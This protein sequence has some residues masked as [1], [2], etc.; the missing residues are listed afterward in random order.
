MKMLIALT[1]K[2]WLAAF[3]ILSMPA[4]G[5]MTAMAEEPAVKKP[6]GPAK[7][8]QSADAA[9]DRLL[10]TYKNAKTYRDEGLIVINLQTPGGKEPGDFD[11]KLE[12]Q[13]PNLLRMEFQPP[14]PPVGEISQRLVISDGKQVA[15]RSDG[16]ANQVLVANTPAQDVA[17][18]L[19]ASETVGPLLTDGL[20]GG[21]LMLKLLTSADL[22]APLDRTK[23][24]LLEQGKHEDQTFDRVQF[25]TKE[26]DLTLWID[27][28]TSIVRRIEY[29]GNKLL[30]LLKPLGVTS[31]EIIADLKGAELDAPIA[32]DRFTWKKTDG[33]H[34]VGKLVEPV[35]GTEPVAKLIG[36]PLPAFSF[37]NAKGAKQTSAEFAGKVVVVDFWATWC[38]WCLKG[39]PGVDQVRK[40]Y[41]DNDKVQFIALSEDA[42]EVT[43]QQIGDV[44]KKIKAEVPWARLTAETGDDLNNRFEF[45]GIPAMLVIAADGRVQFHHVGFDSKIEENLPPVIDALLA[46]KDLSSKVIETRKAKQQEYEQRLEGVKVPP[47]GE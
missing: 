20:I 42:P 27:P 16:Y 30:E 46:G 43:D 13:R 41:A 2:V 21:S 14:I 45:P 28:K 34:Y 44:L 36:Q 22:P 26:G 5:T 3:L 33:D 19:F 39:M 11:A 37:T 8:A 17:N 1:T 9:I 4:W 47:P 23:A 29:P 6:E 18:A 25:T 35:A 15:L 38:G 32:K 31:V 40:K 10:A 24:K 7:G 12:F